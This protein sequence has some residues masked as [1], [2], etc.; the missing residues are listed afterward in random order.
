MKKIKDLSRKIQEQEVPKQFHHVEKG[1]GE[2]NN[3]NHTLKKTYASVVRE[4]M[5]K[6][7]FMEGEGEN[8]ES[9]LILVN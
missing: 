1:D 6:V 8:N 7:R 5:K 2:R 3:V 4:E 9:S